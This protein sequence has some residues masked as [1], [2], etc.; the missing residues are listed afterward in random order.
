M[1]TT[2]N[3]HPS[4]Q[5]AI[6]HTHI[7]HH[8]SFSPT[9][10][11]PATKLAPIFPDTLLESLRLLAARPPLFSTQSKTNIHPT[12]SLYIS[13]LF[14]AARHHPQ[15]DGMLLTTRARQD[16]EALA[17]AGRIIGGDLTGA[18]F[19]RTMGKGA[20]AS[21]KEENDIAQEN[22]EDVD[23]DSLDIGL[24]GENI[25]GSPHHS[26]EAY[27]KSD[28][29]FDVSE[30]DIARIV[31]RVLSH[32]LRVRDGPEDEILGSLVHTA[33]RRCAECDGWNNGDDSENQEK[34]EKRDTV[35]DIL[36]KILAE[37]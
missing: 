29:T 36:V 31:P 25:D 21:L 32:R 27:P 8:N 30:A 18:E 12:L 13:D 26:A 23:V 19:I 2:I 1:S 10:S 11:P 17:R 15:L 35:K 20:E 14:S 28:E 6:R 37:V 33:V 4:T 3:L 7:Y 9:T 22:I 34:W 16:V 24:D 5:Q